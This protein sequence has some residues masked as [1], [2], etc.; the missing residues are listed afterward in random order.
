M[1]ENLIFYQAK[2]GPGYAINPVAMTN[3]DFCPV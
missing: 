3:F 1:E 2:I